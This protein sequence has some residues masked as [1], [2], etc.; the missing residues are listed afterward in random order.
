ME[1]PLPI[2]ASVQAERGKGSW[3]TPSQEPK[4]NFHRSNDKQL[5]RIEVR[6]ID[7]DLRIKTCS[8]ETLIIR[9]LIEG[10]L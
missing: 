1:Q 10:I 8:I 3:K 5:L 9:F 2:A 7:G 4:S 6:W